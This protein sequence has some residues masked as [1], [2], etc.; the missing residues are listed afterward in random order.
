VPLTSA[1][2]RLLAFGRR[3]CADV[4][5]IWRSPPVALAT[6]PATA[7]VRTSTPSPAALHHQP[8][9]CRFEQAHGYEL[10][11]NTCAD[12]CGHY[13]QI[14]WEETRAIGFAVAADRYR[15]DPPGNLIGSA[16]TRLRTHKSACSAR[17][18]DCLPERFSKAPLRAFM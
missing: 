4:E 12:V 11:S 1:S 5:C 13:T 15:D 2:D 18:F 3:I 6:A 14:V 7:T 17:A 10:R 16:A 8:R 9:C